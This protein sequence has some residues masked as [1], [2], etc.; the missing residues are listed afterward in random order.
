MNL[1]VYAVGRAGDG[2]LAPLRGIF[3][4]P[5]L[6]FEAGP[7]CAI[8]SESRESGVRAERKHII[9]TQRVLA[10]LNAEFDILPMAFGT[11]SKSEDDLRSFLGDHHESLSAQLQRISGAIE[12]SLR[13][14]LG[15]TD[16][17]A[18]LVDRTPALQSARERIFNGRRSPSNDSKIRL[19]QMFEDA[20]RQ[21]REAHTARVVATVEPS[22]AEVIALPV[23]GDREIANLAALVPRSGL[24]QFEAA[25]HASAAQIDEDIAFN[26]GGPWPPHNFVQFDPD[27]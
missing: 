13:L 21:Y 19:G 4:S 25:V 15:A 12:M 20:L 16:P 9:A 27:G 1:Y 8:V 2:E 24:D 6:R 10:A 26:I 17:V 5:V 3:D 18:Y 11:I 23:R 14:N 7:L 22:C